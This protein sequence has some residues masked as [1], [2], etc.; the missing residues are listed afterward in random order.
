MDDLWNYR[1]LLVI[2]DHLVSFIINMHVIYIATRPNAIFLYR[3]RSQKAYQHLNFYLYFLL[4]ELKNINVLIK[5]DLR[6]S[7]IGCLKSQ[8]TIFQSYM[9]RHRWIDSNW[10]EIFANAMGHFQ[11][12]S[13]ILI[14]SMGHFLSF[15]IGFYGQFV[16]LMGLWRMAPCLPNHWIGL[17]KL[18][19]QS[20]SQRN[21]HFVGFFNV[22]VQS[23]H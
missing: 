16:K 9:R 14:F 18:N 21:R 17:K 15:Y 20:G 10:E 19:L 23:F 5:S 6:V 4:I 7:E 11:L 13:M 1:G 8:A 12:F 2:L 22:S 3:R